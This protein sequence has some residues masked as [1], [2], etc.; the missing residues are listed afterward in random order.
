MNMLNV[1]VY[2]SSKATKRRQK[3]EDPIPKNADKKKMHKLIQECAVKRKDTEAI[4]IMVRFIQL[5]ATKTLFFVSQKVSNKNMLFRIQRVKLRICTLPK[6]QKRM[7][8]K[9]V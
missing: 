4:E 6:T 2:E 1:S 7:C 5:S 8:R 3:T 9:F